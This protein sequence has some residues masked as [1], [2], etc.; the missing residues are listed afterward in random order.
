MKKL[1][2][3]KTVLKQTSLTDAE[4]DRLENYSKAEPVDLPAL[5][6]KRHLQTETAQKSAQAQ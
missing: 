2:K 5:I 6:A 3:D 4:I 1:Q